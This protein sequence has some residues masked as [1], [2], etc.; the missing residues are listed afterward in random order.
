MGTTWIWTS[1]NGRITHNYTPQTSE[2]IRAYLNRGWTARCED[3]HG[4]WYM[5]KHPAGLTITGSNK[6]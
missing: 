3:Q 1:P 4:E 6:P 2:C 5:Q